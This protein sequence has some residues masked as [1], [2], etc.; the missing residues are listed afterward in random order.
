MNAKPGN[1]HTTQQTRPSVWP[2]T[3]ERRIGLDVHA[4]VMSMS[5][6]NDESVGSSTAAASALRLPA[7]EATPD[8]FSRQLRHVSTRR[9]LRRLTHAR[10]RFVRH[11]SD[12]SIRQPGADEI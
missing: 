8:I 10:P 6:F 7:L 3:V 2:E 12:R 4:G 1:T 11:V 9:R 5:D